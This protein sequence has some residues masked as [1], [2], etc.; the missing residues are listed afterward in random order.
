MSSV[1]SN[2]TILEFR[3]GEISPEA[4]DALVQPESGFALVTCQRSL[5]LSLDPVSQSKASRAFHG[6]EAY[7]YFL[8]FACGLESKIQGETDVFGQ[9]KIAFKKLQQDNPDLADQFRGFFSCW[10]EDTKEI[11]AQFLQNVGGNNYGALARR[12]LNPKA[13]DS[14]VI[15]G[16]GLVSKTVA[17]YFA[18]LQLKVWNRSPERL[19]DLAHQLKRKG[20]K[21][22]ALST[23]EALI[24]ALTQASIVILAT[25]V[26][27]KLPAGVTAA[28]SNDA[29][30]LHL[31]GQLDQLHCNE[32]QSLASVF[33]SRLL[34]LSDLF[35]I[36]REQAQIRQKQ[37]RQALDACHQRSL[38]R[39]LARSIHIAHGWEDLALFY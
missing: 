3:P 37:V 25:P 38:L 31:G 6:F 39:N 16:A 7:N 28:I 32:L 4:L 26:D 35:E 22:Q 5:L 24:E 14:V 11:R 13:T 29:R 2:L 1:F 17:P 18:E 33:G 12:L 19:I 20:N 27:A 34:T 21:F 9:V 23:I 30:V 10:L 15:L 8:R 36:D